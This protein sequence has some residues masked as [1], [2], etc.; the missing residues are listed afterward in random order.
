MPCPQHLLVRGILI[1]ASAMALL[2]AGCQ[3]KQ[4][5]AKPPAPA[6]TPA[7]KPGATL[8]ADHTTINQGESVQLSWNTTDASTA[9]IS[10]GVGSVPVQGST[11]VKP[12]TSTTYTLTAS[13]AGGS[14]ESS[15]RISVS[16]PA[17]VAAH[18]PSLEEMFL[19]EVNDA[20]FDYDSAS[21]RSD[22]QTALQKSA[23]FL[24][25]YPAARVTIE[26]HCDERGSTEYNLALGQRRANA[27]KQYLVSLGV[28]TDQVATTSWG[29][30]RPFCTQENESCWQEN[31]RGHFSLNK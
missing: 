22:A 23:V 31:R 28:P 24:K 21:I 2:I 10:P 1:S 25:S 11:A 27:V 8:S 4:V 3:K 18:Q 6:P 20:Y 13:G 16:V 19:K 7:A 9:S 30:E 17:P 26:G 14:T 12:S 5:A 29:K 15:V